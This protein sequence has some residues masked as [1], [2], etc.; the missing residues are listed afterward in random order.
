MQFTGA[1]VAVLSSSLGSIGDRGEVGVVVIILL[2]LLCCH[3]PAVFPLLHVGAHL[4]RCP[5]SLVGLLSVAVHYGAWGHWR[6]TLKV[7]L[8]L[9]ISCTN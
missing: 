8:R 6:L 5:R 2:L 7:C 9:N 3:T 4:A 1:N